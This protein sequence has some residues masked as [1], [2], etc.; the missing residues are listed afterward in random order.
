MANTL[1]TAE[2]LILASAVEALHTTLAPLGAFSLNTAGRDGSTM[3]QKGDSVIVKVASARTAS[4]FSNNYETSGD[5]TWTDKTVSLNQDK[6]VS[7]HMTDLEASENAFEAINSAAMEAAEGLAKAVFQN[8]TDVFVDG[9]SFSDTTVTV[10]NMGLDDVRTLRKLQN[11]AGVPM[12][13]RSI[14][15]TPEVAAEILAETSLTDASAIGSTA[16]L[17][18]GAIGRLYGYD[19]FETASLSTTVTAG[20]SNVHTIAAHPSCLGIGLRVVPPSDEDLATSAGLRWGTM[21]HPGSGI[22]LGMRSWYNTGT[23][24]RWG[25][26]RLV[27]GKTVVHA[28]S[29]ELIKSS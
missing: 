27:W 25:S 22:T 8:V 21:T 7:F 15:F 2:R 5:T 1:G 17:R 18:D 6:F 3:A 28:G 29:A 11:E 9:G 4:N 12:T 14:M 20:T 19:I 26:F 10:A 13:N 23:G 16:P 24:I